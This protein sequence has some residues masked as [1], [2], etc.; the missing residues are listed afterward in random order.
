MNLKLKLRKLLS[1]IENKYKFYLLVFI[2]MLF[3]ASFLQILGINSLLPTVASF[4]DNKYQIENQY[5][6]SV[7]EIFSS[8]LGASIF[9]TLLFLSASIIVFSNLIY[10]LV[11]FLASKLAFFLEKELKIKISKELINMEFDKIIQF[12][13]EKTI[14]MYTLEAQRFAIL[15][16]S[17]SD[18]ISR[19]I[20][21]IF[22]TIYL[23]VFFPKIIL[24]LIF[25]GFFYFIV[26]TIIRKKIS[27][28]AIELSKIN[29]NT[30]NIIDQLFK[31]FREL[32]IFN[33]EKNFLKIFTKDAVKLKDIRFFSSFFASSPRYFLE[34]IIFLFL[35]I[36]FSLMDF[37]ENF[38]IKIAKGAVLFF[39]F[40]KLL[41]LVQGLFSQL[42]ATQ[43][44]TNAIDILYNFF[45]KQKKEKIQNPLKENLN[46][47]NIFDN[48][49]YKNINFSINQNNIIKDL[50]LKINKGEI[51]GIIGESGIGKTI[52]LDLIL[53]FRKPQT[54]N[55]EINN[56][57]I[58]QN[59][60]LSF[61]KNKGSIVSQ[62]G[63][64]L[65]VSAL[66]NIILES[67]F[68]KQKL[69]KV[70]DTCLLPKLFLKD[71]SI[72]DFYNRK[73]STMSGGQI[74]RILMAR[75]LYK[76]SEILII[77]EGLNQ[78]DI[79]NEIE[80]FDNIT[81]LGITIIMVYHRISKSKNF[82][83]IYKLSD[84]KLTELNVN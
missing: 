25:L 61:F 74:Q 50:N 72:N 45:D 8:I 46:S 79:E 15:I 43:S 40:F 9:M 37:S 1:L 80:L 4:F 78:L 58:N 2:F 14:S 54:G 56:Q 38:E 11:I 67:K 27:Y 3:F 73:I 83:K 48:I 41:P 52:L 42:V 18:I 76:G 75:S 17:F 12:E 7:V 24:I 69:E 6:S 31:G 39:V 34:I 81:K 62:N 59:E 30:I 5:L 57:N 44:H 51:I 26:F 21:I 23:G 13:K 84:K 10:I 70:L 71:D 19:L 20:L 29:E 82:N 32:K 77:D 64:A 55:I 35:I 65:N 16:N 63:S 47:I 53:G 49:L 68:D 33:L 22:L 28:N 36:I 60:L 66:Q